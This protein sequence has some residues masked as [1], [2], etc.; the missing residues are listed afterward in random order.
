[1]I[2]ATQTANDISNLATDMEHEIVTLRSE[3]ELLRERLDVAMGTVSAQALDEGL[4][5]EAET[6]PEAYLQDALRTLHEV[7]EG[8][9]RE[10]CANAALV[11]EGLAPDA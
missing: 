1:M 7:V 3:G 5:F 2:D 4:W 9:S 8:S 10:E 6:A 11:S